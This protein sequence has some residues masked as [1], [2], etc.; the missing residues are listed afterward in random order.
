V[1]SAFSGPG[2]SYNNMQA[3]DNNS[4]SASIWSHHQVP[5][6]MQDFGS[7]AS[8]TANSGIATISMSMNAEGVFNG[9]DSGTLY[10]VHRMSCSPSI[11]WATV[12]SGYSYSNSNAR[13]VGPNYSN[14]DWYKFTGSLAD[15]QVIFSPSTD[16]TTTITNAAANTDTVINV[17]NAIGFPTTG[18][19]F[20]DGEII[21]Y[22]GITPTSFTGCSRGL[23]NTP[24]QGLFTGT[25]VFIGGWFVKIQNGLLFAGYQIPT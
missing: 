18:F 17:T 4:T 20:I 24:S 8:T 7:S 16:Y 11:Q 9:G 2:G 3:I 10:S 6:Q 15:E 25:T 21:S 19:I 13:L 23:Y 5:G 12:W 22:T 14:L 1:L